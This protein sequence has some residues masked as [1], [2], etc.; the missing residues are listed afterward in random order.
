[1]AKDL[2]TGVYESLQ[3]KGQA[4]TLIV[5]TIIFTIFSSFALLLCLYV[6]VSLGRFS[7]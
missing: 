4:L 6:R 1:M 3:P 2:T 7:S 5:V